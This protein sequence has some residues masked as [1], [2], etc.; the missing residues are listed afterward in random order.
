MRLSPTQSLDPLPRLGPSVAMTGMAGAVP[1][2]PLPE[3]VRQMMQLYVA[4][5]QV[6]SPLDPP[7]PPT[8]DRQPP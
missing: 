4:P 5:E 3:V 2:K 1:A 6:Q 8:S 7:R